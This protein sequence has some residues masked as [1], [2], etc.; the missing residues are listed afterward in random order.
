LRKA[1]GEGTV[2]VGAREEEI[3]NWLPEWNKLALGDDWLRGGS[4]LRLLRPEGSLRLGDL[5]GLIVGPGRFRRASTALEVLKAS[6]ELLAYKRA[7]M[8][9]LESSGAQSGG[10]QPLRVSGENVR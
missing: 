6:L 3:I 2:V 7:F 1:V 8:S 9:A 5:L 10:S 4:G